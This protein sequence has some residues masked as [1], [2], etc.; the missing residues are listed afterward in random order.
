ME[1]EP[2][3]RRFRSVQAV[4]YHQA[5]HDSPPRQVPR[6]MGRGRRRHWS[7]HCR[8]I[9]AL[10]LGQLSQVARYP[11]RAAPVMARPRY[12]EKKS[13]RIQG[14]SRGLVDAPLLARLGYTGM[15]TVTNSQLDRSVATQT[16]KVVP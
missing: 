6:R 4:R 13:A 8:R 15:T 16:V 2:R 10:G 7:G 5:I 14:L 3:S 12:S 1:L 9:A 11:I